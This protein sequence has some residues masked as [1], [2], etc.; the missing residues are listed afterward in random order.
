MR[1]WFRSQMELAMRWFKI[2][3]YTVTE[4][5]IIRREIAFTEINT[6][7]SMEIAFEFLDTSLILCRF[8]HSISRIVECFVHVSINPNWKWD[9]N[10]HS[11][12]QCLFVN[13]TFPIC[14]I[15]KVSNVSSIQQLNNSGHV[16]STPFLTIQSTHNTNIRQFTD[17]QITFAFDW[18]VY[19][20]Y[21]FNAIR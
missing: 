15:S 6:N 4:K 9:S 13:D 7:R 19:L 12:A 16:I 8:A 18:I 20:L 14:L 5:S 10:S 11:Y 17:F 3:K 2:T 21:R 1:T